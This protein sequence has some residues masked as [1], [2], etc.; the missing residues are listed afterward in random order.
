MRGIN[1]TRCQVSGVRSGLMVIDTL[2]GGGVRL[3][4]RPQDQGEGYR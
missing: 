1:F 4:H 3:D 2:I